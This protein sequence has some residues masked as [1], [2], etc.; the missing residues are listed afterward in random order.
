MR[1]FHF[2]SRSLCMSHGQP[3]V[4]HESSQLMLPLILGAVNG[5]AMKLLKKKA[6]FQQIN[7]LKARMSEEV[8]KRLSLG[9]QNT[10]KL[11]LPLE[12]SE[13][14]FAGKAQG[15]KYPCTPPAAAA[16]SHGVLEGCLR[17]AVTPEGCRGTC[18]AN[19]GVKQAPLPRGRQI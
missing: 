6:E 9:I 3:L 7:K 19:Y 10:E 5:K 18:W 17:G 2:F 12:T 13:P 11:L 14:G 16:V 8:M 15:E 4:G 1:D